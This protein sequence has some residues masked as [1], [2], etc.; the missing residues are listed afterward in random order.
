MGKAKKVCITNI[1]QAAYLL[2]AGENLVKTILEGTRVA[3]VF[4]KSSS[5]QEKISA[6][7]S[8][9][10]EVNVGKY[11]AFYQY[12]KNLIYMEKGKFENEKETRKN[13]RRVRPSAV[14]DDR[15]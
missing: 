8:G 12:L 6:F 9:A 14:C 11:I 3:F 1:W 13:E 5:L 2:Y 4:N 10:V 7:L 15:E